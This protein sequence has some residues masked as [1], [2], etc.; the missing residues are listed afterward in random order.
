MAHAYSHLFR[1]PTTGLRFFTVYGPWGWPD[2]AYFSFTK[3]IL[4]GRPIDIYNHGRIQRDF[5]FVDDIAEG[6]TRCLDALPRP[7][8]CWSGERPDPGTSTAPYRI[9]N[10]GTH[11]PVELLRRGLVPRLLRSAPAYGGPGLTRLGCTSDCARRQ[12]RAGLFCE[13]TTEP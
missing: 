11:Q 8:P 2:M 1:I 5:T 4:T 13:A 3:A 12:S 10:I 6:V 9:Y 7:D